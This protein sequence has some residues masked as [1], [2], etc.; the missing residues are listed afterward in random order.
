M[1]IKRGQIKE[2]RP[3]R[4]QKEAKGDRGAVSIELT[5]GQPISKKLLL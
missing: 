5:G 1:K 2:V 4:R 3:G